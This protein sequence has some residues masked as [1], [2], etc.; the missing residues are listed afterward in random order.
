MRMPPQ[1]VAI[2][3]GAG[4]GQI[5]MNIQSIFPPVHKAMV[6]G[7]WVERTQPQVAQLT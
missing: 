6:C 1:I 5:Q 7:E 3:I 4:A 2:P